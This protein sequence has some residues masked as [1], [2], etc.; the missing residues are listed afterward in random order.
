[1]K[2]IKKPIHPEIITKIVLGD[3]VINS[4]QK[5][6]TGDECEIIDSYQLTAV[7]QLEETYFRT[8]K[9]VK[10]FVEFAETVQDSDAISWEDV[11]FNIEMQNT[12]IEVD[13]WEL[14]LVEENY[15]EHPHAVEG[16][17]EDIKY[18]SV[19]ISCDS[20][21]PFEVEEQVWTATES[22]R[23]VELTTKIE[24]LETKDYK[25]SNC[26]KLI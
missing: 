20:V 6:D 13:D 5:F 10:D 11:E 21:K 4:S 17:L 19:R 23:S 22:P 7:T 9:K 15:S 12:I 25:L 1:M 18:K 24:K 14:V 26:K 8:E 16:K 2:T 3:G